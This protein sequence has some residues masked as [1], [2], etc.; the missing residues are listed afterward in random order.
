MP[1]L[2]HS[3]EYFGAKRREKKYDFD[4]V[5]ERFL[6]H[7]GAKRRENFSDLGSILGHF[8]LCRKNHVKNKRGKKKTRRAKMFLPRYFFSMEQS[9][10]KIE[11][12][13]E[14]A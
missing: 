6:M 5:F 8:C 11:I 12:R 14:F 10:I 13:V 1:F 7:F 3:K 9:T 2:K 4:A